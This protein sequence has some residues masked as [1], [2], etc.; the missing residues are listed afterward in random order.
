MTAICVPLPN[1]SNWFRAG[2]RGAN[3]KNAMSPPAKIRPIKASESLIE[4]RRHFVISPETV[5]RNASWPFQ[6]TSM[7]AAAPKPGVRPP[8]QPT[9]AAPATPLPRVP[10]FPG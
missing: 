6:N 3:K 10:N 4:N 1:C 5:I 7:R 9:P 8:L 2:S